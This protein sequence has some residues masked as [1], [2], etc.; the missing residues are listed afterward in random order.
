[1]KILYEVFVDVKADDM[2]GSF[3]HAAFLGSGVAAS[4]IVEET[5]KKVHRISVFLTQPAAARRLMGVFKTL[6]LKRVA[7]KM[8]VHRRT[9][10]ESRWKENWKPFPLTRK[11]HVIPLFLK[12]AKCPKGKTPFYLDTTAAFGTGL[13]E[14]TRFSA[15]LIE[16]LQGKFQAV[17]D[18]G[19]GTGIL[20]AVAIMSGASYVEAFDI[21]A[22]A[23]KVAQKNLK[24]NGLRCDILK[25]CDV[26]R[27]RVA[28]QFDLV[29]ANLITHDLV[30]FKQKI[31]ACV[32]PGKYLIISGISLKN[33]PLVKREYNASAGLKCLKVIKGKEWSAFLF[34]KVDHDR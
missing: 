28:R 3:V 30:A 20:A 29:A 34:R 12:N 1:V 9:D 18:V 32:Q 19:T 33:M 17:L 22:S 10:W 27:Y 31:M 5:G 2:S 11:I 8:R 13:H 6:G 26:Q 23:V 7:V 14:T 21:D 25:A 15:Q 16:G 24:A 4:D